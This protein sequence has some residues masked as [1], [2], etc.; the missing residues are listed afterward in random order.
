MSPAIYFL[1]GTLARLAVRCRLRGCRGLAVQ[2]QARRHLVG[3]DEDG[4]AGWPERNQFRL[5]ALRV[6]IVRRN[7]GVANRL[8]LEVLTLVARSRNDQPAHRGDVELRRRHGSGNLAPRH[9]VPRPCRASGSPPPCRARQ[10]G[11]ALCSGSGSRQAA[12]GWSR[13]RSSCAWSWPCAASPCC[14][15][16]LPR[17]RGCG[18][19]SMVLRPI[20]G[21]TPFTVALIA[22]SSTWTSVISRSH[23]LGVLDGERVRTAVAGEGD[24]HAV[25]VEAIG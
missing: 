11:R 14:T 15:G 21:N 8:L 4:L 17:S 16:I 3:R 1:H 19:M 10:N 9:R 6:V 12:P 18:P 2:P 24:A 5:V 23:S 25:P 22:T 7:L 20:T 13:R